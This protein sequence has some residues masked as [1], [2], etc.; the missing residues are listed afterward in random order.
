MKP[1]Q[2]VAT[3]T[4]LHLWAAKIRR[5]NMIA[6][7]KTSREATDLIRRI[8]ASENIKNLRHQYGSIMEARLRMT[9]AMQRDIALAESRKAGL[10]SR[11]RQ[12]AIYLMP[13][14]MKGN[15]F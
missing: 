4:D 11:L 2:K 9:P 15:G 3:R 1:T 14:H 10:E 7:Y 8:K 13:D 12:E 6:N 5:Q